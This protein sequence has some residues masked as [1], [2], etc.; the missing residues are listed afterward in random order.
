MIRNR[1]FLLIFIAISSLAFTSCSHIAFWK[2]PSSDEIEQAEAH[3]VAIIDELMMLDP[4]DD[5]ERY[6]QVRTEF[7]EELEQYLIITGKRDRSIVHLDYKGTNI[8]IPVRR[9]EHFDDQIQLMQTETART[10]WQR[11]GPVFHDEIVDVAA[12]R[13]NDDIVKIAALFAD[14]LVVFPSTVR[15]ISSPEVI[16]PYYANQKIRSQ[17]PAGMIEP[18][19]VIN[20]SRLYFLTAHSDTSFLV[21]ISDPGGPP[22]E[23]AYPFDIRPESGRPYFTYNDAGEFENIFG[24]RHMR[25]ENR[26]VLLDDRGMVRVISSEDGSILW[27]SG[28]PWGN[29][30]FNINNNK[31]AV[32]HPDDNSFIL[33]KLSR[34]TVVTHGASPRFHGPVT[35]VTFARLSGVE[36]YIV[37]VRTGDR[38]AGR[39]SQLHFI[40]DTMMRWRDV[41]SVPHPFFPDYNARFVLVDNVGDILESPYLHQ[42]EH[43]NVYETIV[44]YDDEG[45]LINI[46]GSSVQADMSQQQWTIS[47]QPDIYFSDGTPLNAD[48]VKESWSRSI[49]E[50]IENNHAMQ[51]VANDIEEIQVVD[52]LT[53][54]I[55]L[56]APR[57]NFGAHLT[58][59]C[60]QIAK[61]SSEHTRRIGTGPYMTTNTVRGG[62]GAAV[63]YSRNPYYHNGVASL[64]EITIRGRQTD[65]ID[66]VTGRD[67]AGA[68]IRQPRDIDF[69]G[70]IDALKDLKARNKMIYFVALNPGSP[71][72]RNTAARSR[73]IQTFERQAVLTVVTGAR[74]ETATS[75]F[76]ESDEPVA[77]SNAG[78][79]P[80]VS[81]S[82]RIV[83]LAQDP[84]AEQIAQRL[85]VRL[86]QEGVSTQR[87]EGV[88]RTG[89]K[90]VRRDRRYDIL[91]DSFLPYFSSPGYNIYDLL[92]RGFIFDDELREKAGTLLTREGDANAAAIE[93]YITDHHYLYPL[94]RTSF[95]TVVPRELHDIE[96]TSGIHFNFYRAWFPQ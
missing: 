96:Y 15:D 36:G 38:S 55:Y 44:V 53:L 16:T 80:P 89:L 14:S 47:L 45:E 68:L 20:R 26:T 57:P 10:V 40:P 17:I 46:L 73:I 2:T 43:T 85:A 91:V 88:S 64:A 95:H 67:N 61:E 52:S 29:R 48:I 78:N 9:I 32:T 4:A 75:F 25:E 28:R 60:F 74:S 51:W 62:G 93:A 41:E 3:L 71:H 94:I 65:V 7:E 30:L 21:D 59:A 8:I 13:M 35:A 90:Q 63:T 34:D 77:Y 76:T 81:N 39:Y 79:S 92:S 54:R 49:G 18:D 6:Y 37:G 22:L 12:I 56:N 23:Y 82:L 50:C 87:P 69:F 84:V 1:L 11:V 58:A 86:Q 24:V 19:T 5:A 72:L 42:F 83:Y 31:F 27:D 70:A 66:Y 33:F